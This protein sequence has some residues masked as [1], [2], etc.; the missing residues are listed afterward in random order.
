[1]RSGGIT[2]LHPTREGTLYISANTPHFWKALC[3]LLGMP[4]LAANSRFDTVRKLAQHAAELI[5]RIR[6]ALRAHSA[7]EWEAIFGERVPCSAVRQVEDMFE[8]PQVLAEGMVASFAHPLVGSYRGLASAYRFGGG[9][10]AAPRAA[11][12]F[13]QHTDAILGEHGYDAEA[14]A[15]MRAAGVIQ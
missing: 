8:H 9:R 3:E 14:I 15:Q 11:P 2:G 6:E 1:M 10:S 5:P 12:M 7:L 4:E 13:G